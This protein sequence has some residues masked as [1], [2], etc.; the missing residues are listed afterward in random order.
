M[1]RISDF[2]WLLEQCN[3]RE[4]LLQSDICICSWFS[5]ATPSLTGH[6]AEYRW[7]KKRKKNFWKR[8]MFDLQNKYIYVFTCR[9]LF[10]YCSFVNMVLTVSQLNLRYLKLFQDIFK[11]PGSGYT[12][13]ESSLMFAVHPSPVF[14]QFLLKGT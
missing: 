10:I 11:S 3:R 8:T 7:G 5:P 12:V 6:K 2:P 4:M 13:L 1:V 9:E 14:P